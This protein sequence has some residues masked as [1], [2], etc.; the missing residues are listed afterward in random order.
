MSKCTAGKPLEESQLASGRVDDSTKKTLC[1]MQKNYGH[2]LLLCPD[3]T[4]WSRGFPVGVNQLLTLSICCCFCNMRTAKLW[5]QRLGIF[6]RVHVWKQLMRHTVLPIDL[7]PHVSFKRHE[8]GISCVIKS[9]LLSRN[10]GSELKRLQNSK[11]TCSAE[12]HSVM[13]HSYHGWDSATGITL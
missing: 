8:V 4:E 7:F 2:V 1:F 13:V 5:T 11:T 12:P 10:E 6:S 9:L 3:V